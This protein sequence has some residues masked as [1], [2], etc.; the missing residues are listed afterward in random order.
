MS[1]LQSVSYEIKQRFPAARRN[2][3]FDDGQMDLVLDFS[4][5]EGRPWRRMTS[6][7]AI[8]RKKKTSEKSGKF[9]LGAGEID[10]LLDDR[11]DEADDRD[12]GP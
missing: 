9:A 5:S 8:E 2:V 4:V 7:Q 10:N 11:I 1:A 3:L 12:A 6:L